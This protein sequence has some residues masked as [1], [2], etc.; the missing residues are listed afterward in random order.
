ME[1]KQSLAVPKQSIAPAKPPAPSRQAL[2]LRLREAEEAL[3]AI[4]SGEVD[5][6]IVGGHAGDKVFTIEGADH[7]YRVFVERMNEGAAVLSLNHT[8]LHCNGRFAGLLGAGIQQVI[9][10]SMD[11]LVCPRDRSRLS[12][13]LRRGAQTPCRGEIDLQTRS[14]VG[15]P[16]R[17]SL[18]PLDSGGTQ[19][20]CLIASDLS[21]VKR[22]ERE[23]RES[24]EQLRKLASHQLSVL[25]DERTR[26]AREIHDD[27]GQSL[28]AV[29]MDVSWL[30]SRMPAGNGQI[31]ERIRATVKLADDLIK[32]VRRISTALRPGILDLGLTSAVEWQVQE[33]QT[34][35][36]I[37]CRLFLPPHEVAVASNVSTAL[38]RIFQEALTNIARHAECTTVEVNLEEQANRVILRVRDQG[39]GFDETDPGLAKSLGLLGMR[40]RA[41]M[42]GGHV[43]IRSSPGEGTSV[44]AWIP[45]QTPERSGGTPVRNENAT[46]SLAH[47]GNA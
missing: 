13:L 24:G 29:K 19:A 10:S 5:A 3:Q 9:G 14:G 32:S 16:V 4:R 15:L 21:E 31:Q 8:V 17:L 46:P 44:T 6:I 37:A 26:I 39:R 20:I 33:F 40:E 43:S 25:E 35:T 27:L 36:G 18:N 23:L 30:A 22:V 1:I 7:I 12:D 11:E 34:R 42:L 28:T 45:L 38:F 47:R 41:A 2:I